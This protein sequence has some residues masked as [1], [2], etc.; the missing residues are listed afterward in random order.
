MTGQALRALRPLG[1][2]RTLSLEGCRGVPLLDRGLGEAAPGLSS[3]SSLS[4]QGCCTLSDEGLAALAPLG[5]S[6]AALNLS[7]CPGVT[8]AGLGAWRAAGGAPRLATLALQNC[9]GVDDRGMGALAA[10]GATAVSVRACVRAC[11]R[12]R[13][14]SGG[15]EMAGWGA[16]CLRSACLQHAATHPAPPRSTTLHAPQLRALSIKHCKLV[17]DQGLAAVAPTLQQLTS[18]ALQVR[19]QAGVRVCVWSLEVAAPPPPPRLAKSSHSPPSTPYSHLSCAC[20]PTLNPEPHPLARTQGCPITD[21]GVAS[22][23][24]LRGL[25]E[26]EL[27][28]CWQFTDEGESCVMTRHAVRLVCWAGASDG[29]GLPA[30]PPPTRPRPRPAARAGIAALASGL[31]ALSRLDLMYSWKV[32]V[33]LLLCTPRVCYAPNCARVAC[34]R[35]RRVRSARERSAHATLSS[36]RTSLPHIPPAP[37]PRF[38]PPMQVG[39]EAMHTLAG[40]T[41]LL[42]LNVLGCHR[43]TAA[44]KA[45]VA[46]LLDGPHTF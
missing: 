2:L 9:G 12:V 22:L 19:S 35:S 32:R 20:P 46:H 3:L 41:S 28:F 31:S 44:G 43:I 1:A 21:A 45:A 4:L 33:L 7:D 15:R 42:A 24:H 29:Q 11:V 18:L 13:A 10:A 6:L 36:L 8:G 17:S 27:Q 37:P 26:L 25:H 14:G 30:H 16:L 38:M 23:G 40:M 5:R 39:D 34:M